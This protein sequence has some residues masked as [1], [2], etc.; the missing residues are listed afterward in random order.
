MAAR[1]LGMQECQSGRRRIRG[2]PWRAI[3]LNWPVIFSSQIGRNTVVY[4]V[5]VSDSPE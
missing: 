5:Q 1:P 3:R 4:A 2:I